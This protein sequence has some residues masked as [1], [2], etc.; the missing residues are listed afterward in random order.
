[1]KF[2]KASFLAINMLKLKFL[3]KAKSIK[4][5]FSMIFSY[6]NSEV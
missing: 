4:N 3:F 2:F 5:S 6:P 1:M